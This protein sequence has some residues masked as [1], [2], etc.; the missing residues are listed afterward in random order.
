MTL[1][2]KDGNSSEEEGRIRASGPGSIRVQAK[3]IPFPGCFCTAVVV[4]LRGDGKQ[5]AGAGIDA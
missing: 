1:A 3:Q 5:F 2:G 4:P